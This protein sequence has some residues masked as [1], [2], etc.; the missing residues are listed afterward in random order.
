MSKQIEIRCDQNLSM[1]I[2]RK[3][4]AKRFPDIPLDD[5]SLNELMGIEGAR[6]KTL[7]GSLA[8]KYGVQWHGRQY[9]PGSYQKGDLLNQNLTFL[10][11]VLYGL[12]TSVIHHIGLSPYIGFIHSNSPLP[13]VYDIADLYKSYYTIDLAFQLTATGATNFQ[14]KEAIDAFQKRANEF[15]LL[16]NIVWDIRKIMEL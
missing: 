3:M 6:V 8:Q 13:F 4:F 15:G 5:K 7:Y 1:N 12:C 2:A 11:S 10:N 16:E 14:R 9:E